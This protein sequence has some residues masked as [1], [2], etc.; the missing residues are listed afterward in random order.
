[1]AKAW[2]YLRRAP[3]WIWSVLGVLGMIASLWFLIGQRD[4]ARAEAEEWKRRHI[5]AEAR[6]DQVEEAARVHRAHLD[7]VEAE[8]ARWREIAEDL[9]SL[10]GTDAP[11]SPYLRAVL[12]RVR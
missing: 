1:M 12:D 7:R 8:A 4:E 3:G 6:L 11:L 2:G 5:V 10:E 9:Q